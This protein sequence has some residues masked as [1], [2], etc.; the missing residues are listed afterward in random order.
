ME[1]TLGISFSG[2]RAGGVVRGRLFFETRASGWESPGGREIKAA[3]HWKAGSMA[4]RSKS[5]GRATA[6]MKRC[7]TIFS[8]FKGLRPNDVGNVGKDDRRCLISYVATDFWQ[9]SR[10]GRWSASGSVVSRRSGGVSWAGLGQG[11]GKGWGRGG[12]SARL[13]REGGRGG[14]GGW[15]G[16]WGS[17]AGTGTS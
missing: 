16:K 1:L 9:R 12:A 13:A 15:V 2:G 8:A 11:K 7:V 17:A 10:R 5:S 14:Q 3:P 4:G 6:E